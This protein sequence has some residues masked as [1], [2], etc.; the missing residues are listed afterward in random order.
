RFQL[1]FNRRD[2]LII[3]TDKVLGKRRSTL[4][5]GNLFSQRLNLLPKLLGL[6]GRDDE[7]DVL[8]AD[9][10]DIKL[11]AERCVLHQHYARRDASLRFLESFWIY[12]HKLL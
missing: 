7:F 6:R 1:R 11:F 10:E 12:R 2:K 8:F 9:Q 3:E 5:T 4:S